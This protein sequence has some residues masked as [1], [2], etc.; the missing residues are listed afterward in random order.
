MKESSTFVMWAIQETCIK[1]S[2]G[3]PGA[4]NVLINLFKKSTPESLECI[5]LLSEYE[6]FGT[7][8]YILANDKCNGDLEKLIALVRATS[9]GKFDKKRLKELSEDQINEINISESE[10]EQLLKI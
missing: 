9:K 6:I 10:F 3:N 7:D 4:L 1:L 5:Q 2:K 8:I